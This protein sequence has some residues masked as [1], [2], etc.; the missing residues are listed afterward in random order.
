MMILFLILNVLLNI[1]GQLKLLAV[2]HCGADLV[3]PVEADALDF[4]DIEF[5]SYECA[6]C[7][8]FLRVVVV[9]MRIDQVL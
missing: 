6:K 7:Q 1:W 3:Q 2:V 9:V 8:I 5:L 4:P